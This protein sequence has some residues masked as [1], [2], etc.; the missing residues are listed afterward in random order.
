MPGV[1]E[2]NIEVEGDSAKRSRVPALVLTAGS[3]PMAERVGRSL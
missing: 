2:F 3:G 1:E